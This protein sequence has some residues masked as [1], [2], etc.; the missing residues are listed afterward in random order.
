MPRSLTE[1]QNAIESKG[2]AVVPSGVPEPELL[3]LQ[4]AL[5]RL[6]AEVDLGARGGV[7]DSFRLVPAVRAL[8]VG[9][10]LWPLATSVLGSD[11]AAVRGI[12]FDKTPGANW[13]VSWHQDH[14]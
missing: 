4:T 14:T 2:F 12:I 3:G 1:F 9:Q 11:C 6:G 8:A 10:R 13:K 7:R 5:E